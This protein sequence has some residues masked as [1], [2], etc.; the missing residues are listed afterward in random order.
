MT[1]YKAIY[2]DNGVEIEDELHQYNIEDALK[3]AKK[4][5]NRNKWKLIKVEPRPL[6]P[7]PTIQRICGCHRD[8][9]SPTIR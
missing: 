9:L 5:A 3:E 6:V 8:P 2:S 7:A 1:Y 4:V